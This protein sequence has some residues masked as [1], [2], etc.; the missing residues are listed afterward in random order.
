MIYL[1]AV[2][3]ALLIIYLFVAI[4]RPEWL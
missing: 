1:T 4:V 2:I 3:T